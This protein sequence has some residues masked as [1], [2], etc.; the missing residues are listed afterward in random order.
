VIEEILAPLS[1]AQRTALGLE[2]DALISAG[3][4]AGKTRTLV[5]MIA[6]DLLIDG[7]PPEE[8]LV[9]TF[10]RAA[11]ANL[12]AQA[13]SQMAALAGAM[14]P[15][16]AGMWAGT[17]DAI[18]TR[19]IRTHAL[20]LGI[21]PGFTVATEREL[22][23]ARG[24]A[25]SRALDAL[26]G[27]DLRRLGEVIDPG[28]AELAREVY[29]LHED[30]RAAGCDPA[31]LVIDGTP[32]E[33]LREELISRIEALL[34]GELA[35]RK[36]AAAKLSQDL[37]AV[38]ARDGAAL[39]TMRYGRVPDE[40]T[41]ALDRL[42]AD[43]ERWRASL[44]AERTVPWR[45][46]MAEL[47][48]HFARFFARAKERRELMDFLDVTLAAH[49]LVESTP[50]IGG[51]RRVYIDEAQDTNPLQLSIL[52][53]LCAP[54]GRTIAVGDAA[55]SIY[56]FRRAD[57]QAFRD[58]ARAASARGNLAE[59]YRSQPGV[60]DVINSVFTRLEH[61]A[62]DVLVMEPRARADA[63]P[64]GAR[65]QVATL[66]GSDGVPSARAEAGAAIPAI[67]ALRDE[68]GLGNSDVCILCQTNAEAS[69]YAQALRAAGIP[70]LLIQR[71][72]LLAQDEVLDA[73]AYLRLLHDPADEQALLRAVSGIFLGLDDAALADA[74]AGRG[75]TPAAEAIARTHPGFAQSLAAMR[76]RVGQEPPSTL[77]LAALQAHGADL[78][79]E[80]L[81]PTGA[82]LR[83]LE[84]LAALLAQLERG[85]DGPSL[86]AVLA[87][88]AAE[89]EAG[90]DEGQ[91]A[92]IPDD[93]DAVRVMTVHN[94]KGLEFEL[95]VVGRLS[96][97]PGR[98][99]R[100][101]WVDETGA[102]GMSLG[103]MADGVALACR[104]QESRVRDEEQRRLVYVAMTRARRA[105]LLVAAARENQDGSPS[106][107]GAARW[108]MPLLGLGDGAIAPG[109]RELPPAPARPAPLVDVRLLAPEV[110]LPASS[111]SLAP[112][113]AFTAE[114]RSDAKRAPVAGATSYSA[115]A[116][117][118][119]CGRRRLLE[120][121]LRLADAGADDPATVMPSGARA[122]GLAI[123]RHLARRNWTQPLDPA[124]AAAPLQPYLQVVAASPLAGQ[125]QAAT[126]VQ[127]EWHFR[128]ALAHGPLQGSVDLIA[129]TGNEALLV[130]WKSGGA[131]DEVFG[132]DYALQQRLYALALLRSEDAPTRV[133]AAWLHGDGSILAADFTQDDIPYLTD[134]IDREIGAILAQAA[135]PA[136]EE[137]QPFCAGCPG[138]IRGCPV[139][140]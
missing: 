71:R 48:A 43:L 61:V 93:I 14:A 36:V 96:S 26:S 117:W 50:R 81:D 98:S 64:A 131:P 49:R 73:L 62:D 10:T 13:S 113:D 108:L 11:A 122:L 8:I 72:G 105:L 137:E 24:E 53:A 35:G 33:Q 132:A 60:I 80:V 28:G 2:E 57:L 124:A 76:A 1:P 107:R 102:L 95:V 97:P 88:I 129:R 18:C 110:P 46:L 47:V 40:Y 12:I 27:D 67:V 31:Q 22:V 39:S 121:D 38:F 78:A 9:C 126:A 116:L 3:A 4:G 77:L 25:M 92:R 94:A 140:A 45:T 91:S 6:R 135:D 133:R 16:A 103:H 51:F 59:N 127:T 5:A 115:L 114:D 136:A 37:H 106:W 66:L 112:A 100:I 86:P 17:I 139:A 30:C 101:F 54:D 82:R 69:A 41:P 68:L 89:I 104:T 90:V 70:A 85:E 134:E 120:H 7:V 83:N 84:H 58:Q 123:H 99:Q 125:I 20:S 74:L 19:L 44:D 128:L 119:Q 111:G 52:R 79:L 87:R 63:G 118:R 55:Q 75:R 56:A 21:A 138:R 23:P 109:G 32:D 42:R 29:H 15:D 34:E 130:D 65:V